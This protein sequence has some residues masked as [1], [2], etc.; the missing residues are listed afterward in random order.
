MADARLA[1]HRNKRAPRP[2]QGEHLEIHHRSGKRRHGVGGGLEQD[3]VDDGLVLE[4]DL[5][6]RRGQGEDE[7]EIGNRQEFGLPVRQPLRPRL[8]LTLRTMTIAAGVVGD[9]RDAAV[10]ASLDMPAEDAKKKGKQHLRITR[11]YPRITKLRS[12]NFR[13]N[14]RK[15]RALCIAASCR[16]RSS[17]FISCYMAKYGLRTERESG[18]IFLRRG[19]RPRLCD[20][21]L[22]DL[23]GLRGEFTGE[24]FL[25]DGLFQFG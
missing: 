20:S 16:S 23:L 8:P 1:R 5:G 3:R 15:T 12:S 19:F 9:P 24:G 7:V 13:S 6:D 10:V 11:K 18:T 25:Q 14:P 21:F 4:G 17:H 2:G 22:Q